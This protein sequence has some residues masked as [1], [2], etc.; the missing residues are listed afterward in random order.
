MEAFLILCRREI[1]FF[2]TN[3]FGILSIRDFERS[4]FCFFGL[5][6]LSRKIEHH[7]GLNFS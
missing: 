4:G 2:Q 3:S 6:L 5:L 7:V 1:Y